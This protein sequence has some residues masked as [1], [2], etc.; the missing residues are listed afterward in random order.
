MPSRRDNQEDIRGSFSSALNSI[1][2]K[3]Q[4]NGTK[5][6]CTTKVTSK[7]STKSSNFVLH[8]IFFE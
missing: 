3:T 2:A 5:K 1:K 7:S 6:D 4:N 8:S